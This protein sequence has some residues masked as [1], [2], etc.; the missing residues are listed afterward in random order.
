[1]KKDFHD[2]C[3]IFVWGFGVCFGSSSQS[4]GKFKFVSKIIDRI[5][6]AQVKG[7]TQVYHLRSQYWVASRELHAQY[8]VPFIG[9]TVPRSPPSI[10]QVPI[11]NLGDFSKQNPLATP[12]N[13]C[14]KAGVHRV[15]DSPVM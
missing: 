11:R 6:I 7:K 4:I 13:R 2:Q 8:Q 15:G 10:V 9:T 1:M 12:H 3:G 14:E 5:C